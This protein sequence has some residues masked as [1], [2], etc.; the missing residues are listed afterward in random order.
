MVRDRLRNVLINGGLLF[1][2]IVFFVGTIEL[3]LR[4]TG[5]EKG[6]PVPPPIYQQSPDPRISYELKPH[7][8]E[9]AFRHAVTTNSLGFRGPE[10]EPGKKLIAVLGDSITFGYGLADEETMPARLQALLPNHDILNTGV[11][12]YDLEQEV[13]TFERRVTPLTP[14]ALILVFYMNDMINMDAAVLAS[15]GNIVP[16]GTPLGPTCQPIMSGILRFV[17]GRCWLD[18]HSAFYRAVKK[19]LSA[20]TEQRRLAEAQRAAQAHPSSESIPEKNFERY[21]QSLKAFAAKLPPSLPRLFVIWPDRELH[22]PVRVKLKP[23]AES[24]GFRVLDLYDTFGNRAETL[25][26][27]T[28]H[29]SAKTAETAANVIADALRTAKLLP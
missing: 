11:P 29:P 9:K 4:I 24:E 3:G 22:A 5:L 1:G 18:L 25:G 12:G 6:H 17:P 14:S 19:A 13:A 15:D 2:T 23:L 26:W 10:I 28:V 27:D 20:R 21:A 16:A 8:R 7:M